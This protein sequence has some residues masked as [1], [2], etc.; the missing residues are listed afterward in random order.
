M[1]PMHKHI[2]FFVVVSLLA[3][4][5]AVVTG[6]LAVTAGYLLG[7]VPRDLL[8]LFSGTAGTV[9]TAVTA[10]AGPAAQVFLVRRPDTDDDGHDPDE[11]A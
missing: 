7:L 1:A 9:F 11:D 3:V 2:K 4:T 6:G 8:L 5:S 10:L